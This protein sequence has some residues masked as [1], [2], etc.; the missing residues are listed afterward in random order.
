MDITELRIGNWVKISNENYN[1]PVTGILEYG[2]EWY[3]SITG[4]DDTPLAKIEPLLLTREWL[5]RLGFTEKKLFEGDINSQFWVH[6]S[7]DDPYEIF[8]L[9]FREHL[10]KENCN[11]GI[12]GFFSPEHEIPAPQDDDLD[13]KIKEEAS[14]TA[15]KHSI[16][17]VHQLQNIFWELD[18]NLLQVFC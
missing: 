8:A 11:Y 9:S 2:K 4:I 1:G 6:E 14:W 18:N 15:I 7:E 5:I 17:Y 12:V 16:A 3:I 13:F 10:P